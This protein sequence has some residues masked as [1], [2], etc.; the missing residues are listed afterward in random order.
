MNILE[1]YISKTFNL[2]NE[3]WAIMSGVARDP[4]FWVSIPSKD[5][6]CAKALAEIADKIGLKGARTRQLLNE[7]VERGILEKTAITKNRRYVKN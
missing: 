7:L 1:E 2:S 6:T 3:E 4:D 5:N